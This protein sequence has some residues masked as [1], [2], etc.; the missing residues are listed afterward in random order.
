MSRAIQ[1]VVLIR[2]DARLDEWV[3]V[4]DLASHLACISR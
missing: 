2:L 4:A 3:P 1:A